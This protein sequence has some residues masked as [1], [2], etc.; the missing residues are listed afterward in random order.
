MPVETDEDRTALLLS[1]QRLKVIDQVEFLLT[2][3]KHGDRG[4]ALDGDRP[5]ADEQTGGGNPEHGR[6]HDF[7]NA[8]VG[9]EIGDA[10]TDAVV[11]YLVGISLPGTCTKRGQ[12]GA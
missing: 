1:D 5:V 2:V 11:I 4:G 12:S 7:G 10:G 9:A 8:W 6:E 3:Q